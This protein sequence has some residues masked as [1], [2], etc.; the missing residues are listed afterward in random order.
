MGSGE[1]RKGVLV[2]DS[3]MSE[4]DKR[5][6]SVFS[7]LALASAAPVTL[8]FKSRLGV[9]QELG[10]RSMGKEERSADAVAVSVSARLR[11]RTFRSTR[12]ASSATNTLILVVIW[13]SLPAQI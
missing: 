12:R 5:P 9:S 13:A 8:S 2:S 4:D 7:I 3:G 10:V 11:S 1:C 6:N